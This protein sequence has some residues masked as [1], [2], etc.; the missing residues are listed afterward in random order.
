MNDFFWVI[1]FLKKTFIS[2]V[3][4]GWLEGSVSMSSLQSHFL[5]TLEHRTDVSVTSTSPWWGAPE[6]Q[7]VPWAPASPWVSTLSPC[8]SLS[9]ASPAQGLAHAS[10][11]PCGRERLAPLG[12]SSL[13]GAAPLPLLHS[14]PVPVPLG[15]E[16][17]GSAARK[18][19]LSR[20]PAR[21]ALCSLA[22]SNEG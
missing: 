4:S 15:S 17:F 19:L 13:L 6:E 3:W 14:Q 20:P 1:F 8:G 9:D 11:A 5:Q 2:V 16:I 22:W 21:V 12:P 10:G 7:G 18:P